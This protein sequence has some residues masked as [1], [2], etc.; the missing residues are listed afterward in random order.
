KRSENSR[1]RIS[2]CVENACQSFHGANCVRRK[3]YCR[4]RFATRDVLAVSTVT[5]HRDEGVG[6]HFVSNL[7]AKTASRS[8]H[9]RLTSLASLRGV[10][11]V[12]VSG[13]RGRPK[14]FGEVASAR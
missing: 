6:V 13:F 10:P 12:I 9:G 7:T 11:D 8:F 2:V 14:A 5:T 1:P 3:R 4:S